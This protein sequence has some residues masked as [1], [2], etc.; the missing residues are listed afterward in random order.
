MAAETPL[1]SFT[2]HISGKNAKV[3]IYPDRIEWERPRG[4]S[5]GKI[6]AGVL[7]GGLS[8]LATGVKNGKTGSEMIPVKNI[9][10]V[11]T[12]RDGM[13]NT[14]V[15]VITSGNTIDFRVS[16]AEAKQIRETLN[17]LI[18]GGGAAPTAAAPVA[19]AGPDI[20]A[21]LTQLA[22]LRDKGILTNEEFDTKKAELLSRL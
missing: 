16:H 8:V 9:S 14:I 21:Q 18:L 11:A 20:T 7:T 12:K 17:Q 19:A 13:L 2:S 6:T 22:D 3:S 10:S 4:I 1:Y 15:S 5:G